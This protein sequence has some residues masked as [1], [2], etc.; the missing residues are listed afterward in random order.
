VLL[1]TG[2]P[3]KINLFQTVVHDFQHI[4]KIRRALAVLGAVGELQIQ[5]RSKKQE[6]DVLQRQQRLVHARTEPRFEVSI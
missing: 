4:C 6:L 5:F 3:Q 2:P 1:V